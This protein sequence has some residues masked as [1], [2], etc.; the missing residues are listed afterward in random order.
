MI[1]A[2]NRTKIATRMRSKLSTTMRLKLGVPKSYPITATEMIPPAS[3][4]MK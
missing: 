3:P 4:P 1:A 2:M